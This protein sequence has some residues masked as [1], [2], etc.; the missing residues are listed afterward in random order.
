MRGK[1]IGLGILLASM[2][3]IILSSGC[4][5][6]TYMEAEHIS[7]ESVDSKYEI[8]F[9]GGNTWEEMSM[10]LIEDKSDPGKDDL[11][12]LAY[13]EYNYVHDNSFYS[14]IIDAH[15]NTVA[16]YENSMIVTRVSD[17]DIRVVVFDDS[18]NDMI[19]S[20]DF[21]DFD[22]RT[23][24]IEIIGTCD[25][26]YIYPERITW[27]NAADNVEYIYEPAVD[28]TDKGTMSFEEW[29]GDS[30]WF[31]DYVMFGDSNIDKNK[32]NITAKSNKYF[33]SM[34]LTYNDWYVEDAKEIY[35]EAQQVCQKIYSDYEKGLISSYEDCIQIDLN[36]SYMGW[37]EFIDEDHVLV[38]G[39]VYHPLE[40]AIEN[41]SS[42]Y[43]YAIVLFVACALLIWY[44]TYRLYKQ[45]LTYENNRRELTGGIAHELKTPL[46][47]TKGYIENWQYFDEED[48][49]KNSQIMVEEIEHMDKMVMD[50]L[51]LS[52]LEAKARKLNYESVDL[53]ELTQTVLKP[54]RSLID[55]KNLNVTINKPDSDSSLV[56]ADL[57]MIRVVLSNFV[58]NA[59]KYADKKIDITIEETAN[60]VKFTIINDGL[61][62]GEEQVDK[63]WDSF[64][65]VKRR[66]PSRLKSNGIGLAITKNILEQHKAQY[67]CSSVC[68]KTTFW[69]EM[70][71]DKKNV[72]F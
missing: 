43:A 68:C 9:A 26:T 72:D 52:R 42:I 51:E 50:L 20:D 6:I 31:S 24:V 54:L 58:I 65:T 46:A 33:A 41:L 38:Y 18:F 48:R 39:Y 4:V 5:L 14:M 28:N 57:E 12:S 36:L 59:V 16:E 47:I 15:G 40:T 27:V 29:A 62:I 55:E 37:L 69:F 19:E 44:L 17:S 67:G 7:S 3:L 66:N 35:Y 8:W 61:H 63:I 1:Y 30:S 25:D 21:Q 64:F 23:D 60:K 53:Y 10:E 70:K 13:K 34:N 32:Y 49:Q 71:K 22:F 2:I 56:R 45:N 11:I